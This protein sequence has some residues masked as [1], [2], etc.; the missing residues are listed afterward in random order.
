L[1]LPAKAL[2]LMR[3]NPQARKVAAVAAVRDAVGDRATVRK[4]LS[5]Q[6]PRPRRV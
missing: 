2:K 6:L 1:K 4:A 3:T 5:L